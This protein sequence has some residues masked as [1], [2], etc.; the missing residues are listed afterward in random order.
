MITTP[1]NQRPAAG[2]RRSSVL[3]V[4]TAAATL[5]LVSCRGGHDTDSSENASA[6]ASTTRIPN[7]VAP[8]GVISP[9]QAA[10]ILAAYAPANNLANQQRSDAINDRI[11]TGVLSA[12]SQAEYEM[13]PYWDDSQRPSIDTSFTYTEPRFYIPRA[14]PPGQRPFFLAVARGQETH[15]TRPSSWTEYLLFVQTPQG[16]RL[17]AAVTADKG[18]S[19]PAVALDAQGFATAVAPGAPGLAIRPSALASAVVDNYITGGRADGAVLAATPT[20]VSQ[21]GLR[22]ATAKRLAPATV[23]FTAMPNPYPH[24]VFAL[25]TADGGALVLAGETH[26]EHDLAARPG[27]LALGT[28]SG[29]RAWTTRRNMNALNDTFTCNDLAAVPVRGQVRLLGTRCE[30]TFADAH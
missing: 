24:D 15:T 11:E 23:W 2:R 21:R 1:R 17:T 28:H 27:H 7:A 5:A 10:K 4:L 16:W 6:A 3:T 19:M 9:A 14:A 26:G 8:G 22:A 12:Q 18:Q 29:E 25:R 30:L 13:Y 20:V